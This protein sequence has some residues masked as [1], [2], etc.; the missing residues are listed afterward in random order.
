MDDLR[1]KPTVAATTILLRAAQTGAGTEALL[2]RRP[3]NMRAFNDVWVFPGGKVDQ[4]DNSEAAADCIADPIRQRYGAHARTLRIAACRELFEEVGVLL[5]RSHNA[6]WVDQP[7]IE[8]LLSR[9]LEFMA[10]P[11]QFYRAIADASLTLAI[12]TLVPWSRWITPPVIKKRFDTAFFAVIV[13]RDNSVQLYAGEVTETCWLELASISEQI[14]ARGMR[15]APPTTITLLDLQK[16][17]S[18]HA[19]CASMLQ[20]EQCRTIEAIQPKLI[21]VD[22]EPWAVFPWDSEYA[23]IDPAPVLSPFVISEYLR[24]LPGRLLAALPPRGDNQQLC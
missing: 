15:L 6:E 9:R 23:G 8:K 14:V 3:G 4:A 5:A 20:A 7:Q 13:S 10:D 17:Q 22:G 18:T 16:S 24:G 12:D 2:L 21:R 1:D 19:N 11:M